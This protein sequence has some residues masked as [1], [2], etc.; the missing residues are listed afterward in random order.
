MRMGIYLAHCVSC[1]SNRVAAAG[2]LA[3]VSVAVST[4]TVTAAII[5]PTVQ[6]QRQ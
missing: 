5:V 4:A 3:T 1:R 6:A 2:I